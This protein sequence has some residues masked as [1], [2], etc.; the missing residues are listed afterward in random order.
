MAAAYLRHL[1]DK[2]QVRGVEVRTAGVSTIVGLLASQETIQVL[3]AEGLDATRHRSSQLSTD[4]L[5]RASFVFGMTPFH[6][7]SALRLFEGAR[8]KVHLL[9]E[10]S[11]SD[12]KKVQIDDPMGGTLEIYRRCF[13]EIKAAINRLIL[14]P[15]VIGADLRPKVAEEKRSEP[16]AK[17]RAKSSS[18]RARARAATRTSAHRSP[19]AR[20]KAK[21]RKPT[22]KAK[23]ARSKPKRKPAPRSSA[24]SNG[25]GR[26]PRPKKRTRAVK[27]SRRTAKR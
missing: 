7:Q 19:G 3:R 16:R 17:A 11:R 15:E 2:Y 25:K 6:V 22:V 24:R 10:F 5:R 4:M 20:A 18:S 21:A 9:K 8:G 1:L 23:P 26:S 12:L 27:R 13:N 14:L